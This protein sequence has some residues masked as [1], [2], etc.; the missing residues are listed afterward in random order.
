MTKKKNIKKNK[1]SVNFMASINKVNEKWDKTRCISL[2][3]KKE[4]PPFKGF[5]SV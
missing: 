3:K 2:A 4:K 5:T 1:N